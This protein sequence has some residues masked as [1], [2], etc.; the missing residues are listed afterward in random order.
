MAFSNQFHT[1]GVVDLA[2]P[3]MSSRTITTTRPDGPI[4]FCAPAY[5]TPKALTSIGS[6]KMIELT[7]ATRGVLPVSGTEAN[8]TPWMV[9]FSVM[10]T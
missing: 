6:L 10:W 4:F 2:R 7:S 9:S 1:C 8:L 3:S 5:R